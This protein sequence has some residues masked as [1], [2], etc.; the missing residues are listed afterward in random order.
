[1]QNRT[2]ST[3]RIGIGF[4]AIRYTSCGASYDYCS[5]NPSRHPKLRALLADPHNRALTRKSDS[6]CDVQIWVKVFRA[7]EYVGS[8]RWDQ[9]VTGSW[10]LHPPFPHNFFFSFFLPVLRLYATRRVMTDLKRLYI[11]RLNQALCHLFPPFLLCLAT[12]TWCDFW[13]FLLLSSPKQVF[14]FLFVF[15]FPVQLPLPCPFS[16]SYSR[17]LQNF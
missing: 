14:T 5:G 15:P 16:S 6:Y 3:L 2:A 9:S 12:I 1:M 4:H 13:V 17:C 7:I 8:E 11:I 10:A